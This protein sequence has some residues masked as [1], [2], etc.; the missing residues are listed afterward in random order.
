[1]MSVVS[2]DGKMQRSGRAAPLPLDERQAAIVRA[3]MPLLASRGRNVTSRELAEAAGVAEGTIFRAFDN[4]QRLVHAVMEAYLDPALLAA[5][6]DELQDDDT[7][8]GF[9]RAVVAAFEERVAGAVAIMSAIDMHHRGGPPRDPRHHHEG[10]NRGKE[11]VDVLERRL[12][13]WAGSLSVAPR[14]AALFVGS[15]ALTTALPRARRL[16]G[17]DELT[18]DEVSRMILGGILGGDPA[19]SSA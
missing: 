19:A 14:R 11:V 5:R 6:L 2:D 12:E 7:L 18:A 4:K 17:D 15:V 16:L 9:V 8:D 1:M 10:W 3:V 13:P